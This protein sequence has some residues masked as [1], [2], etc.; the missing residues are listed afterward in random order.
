MWD[1][2]L[3]YGHYNFMCTVADVQ[4]GDFGIENETGIWDPGIAVSS[5]TWWMTV[6]CVCEGGPA[7]PTPSRGGHS[8]CDTAAAVGLGQWAITQWSAAVISIRLQWI[9]TTC[10]CQ[11]TTGP[12]RIPQL[13]IADSIHSAS[14]LGPIA[15][16]CVNFNHTHTHPLNDPSSRTTRVSRYQKGKTNLDF[17]E[18]RDSEW[19]WH[20]LDHRQ[21]CTLLQTD[22]HSSTRPLSFLQAGCP[23]CHQTI[24]VKALKA[25]G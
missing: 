14:H 12:G 13:G 16:S 4:S 10:W 19:Q 5:R 23:S 25:L 22:N 20:Q 18:A 24:S 21:V 1:L 7:D 11:R 9:R 6:F 15:L 17:T 8:V 2:L 3:R